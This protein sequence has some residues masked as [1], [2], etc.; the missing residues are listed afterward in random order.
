HEATSDVIPAGPA[1]ERH[2]HPATAYLVLPLF[3]LFNAGVVLDSGIVRALT[4]P[5]GLGVLAGLVI[6]K[7]VGISLASW[8]VIRLGFS[9]LPPGVTWLQIYGCAILAGIGFT[10][11]LFVTELAIPEVQLAAYSKAGI[12]AAST[13]CAAGGYYILR[14]SSS[15][16]N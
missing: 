14:R 16:S 7:Q 6:G 4:H 1:L 12:L 2:L 13:L 3:A 8:L 9:D 15:A 5:V 10:M 11:A